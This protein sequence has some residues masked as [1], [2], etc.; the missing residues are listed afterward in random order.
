MITANKTKKL[1]ELGFIALVFLFLLNGCATI[2]GDSEQEITVNSNVEGAEVVFNGKVIGVTPL[3]TT[4]AKQVDSK[5]EVRKEGYRPETV[6]MRTSLTGAFWGN[7]IIGGILGSATDQ[8]TD[9][10]YEYD[11]GSFQVDL[12]P[13]QA[14]RLEL[15]SL[16][17]E[18]NLRR[19]ILFN[20]NQIIRESGTEQGESLEVLS[21]LLS[22]E[23]DEQKSDLA[24]R[25]LK[26]H[27]ENSTPEE[28]AEKVLVLARQSH[29]P[30]KENK[31][32]R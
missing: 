31:N 12:F 28:F 22:L 17:A 32:F 9:S 10:A 18:T 13:E 23:T 15:N 6:E 29:L 30:L 3:T 26:F 8:S 25:I 20:Y 24:T 14:S 27:K 5:L 21:G 4:V 19:F 16:M 2:F 7:I 11:P 1:I